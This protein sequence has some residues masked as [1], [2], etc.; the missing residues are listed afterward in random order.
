MRSEMRVARGKQ[1]RHY[2]SAARL[3]LLSTGHDRS[4]R[5][6]DP[7]W[8]KALADLYKGAVDVS[9]VWHRPEGRSSPES[10]GKWSRWPGRRLMPDRSGR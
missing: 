2:V 10:F 8:C 5:A 1:E 4:I 6:S 7:I 3:D 9:V